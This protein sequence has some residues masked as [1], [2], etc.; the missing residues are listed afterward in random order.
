MNE[1]TARVNEISEGIAAPLEKLPKEI[2]LA[3][4]K[5]I[6]QTDRLTEV[7]VRSQ[8]ALNNTVAHLNGRGYADERIRFYQNAHNMGVAA[9]LNR[10]LD[11]AKGE[12]I[13]RMDSDDISLPERF[14]EQLA[15]MEAHDVLD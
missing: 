2:N 3:S 8:M 12:Y 13:A 14:A 11:L 5:F 4:E 1:F 9:T 15:Y 6:E 10:G 7:L